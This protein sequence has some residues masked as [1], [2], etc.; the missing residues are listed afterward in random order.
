MIWINQCSFAAAHPRRFTS[1]FD[2]IEMS[3]QHLA[4]VAP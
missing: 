4:E 3:S 2:P 1:S